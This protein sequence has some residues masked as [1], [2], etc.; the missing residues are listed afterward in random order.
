VEATLFPPLDELVAEL[1]DEII[2]GLELRLAFEAWADERD[3]GRQE[4][5]PPRTI[6]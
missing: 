5:P 4:Q 6:V 1:T 3:G 2:A